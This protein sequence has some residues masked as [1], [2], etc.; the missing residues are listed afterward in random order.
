M[1][2]ITLPELSSRLCV[3]EWRG[4]RALGTQEP[5]SLDLAGPQD[6]PS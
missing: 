6:P 3:C 1:K 2:I 4:S 5:W